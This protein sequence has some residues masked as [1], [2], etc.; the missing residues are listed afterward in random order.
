MFADSR[1]RLFKSEIPKILKGVRLQFALL[2]KYR[3]VSTT[4]IS[5]PKNMDK[6]PR[7]SIP[8]DK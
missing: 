6:A 2:F 5:H 3:Q 8:K 1:G 7:T 4:R